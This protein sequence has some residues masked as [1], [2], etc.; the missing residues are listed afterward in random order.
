M[1]AG[2]NNID[3]EINTIFKILDDT[4]KGT[5]IKTS[6]DIL[7]LTLPL[8]VA[9]CIFMVSVF[10]QTATGFIFLLIFFVAILVRWGFGM[11][12]GGSKLSANYCDL[13]GLG[14]NSTFNLFSM[15]FILFYLLFPMIMY[16][17]INWI[18]IAVL[19]F[20]TVTDLLFRHSKG[21]YQ[22]NGWGDLIG[23]VFGGVLFG[24]CMPILLIAIGKPQWL[25]FNELSSNTDVCYLPKKTQFKCSVYKNG[26][27]VSSAT[28]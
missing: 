5:T 14:F 12:L 3:R 11:I 15:T 24:I 23:N 26:Q 2:H 7:M 13:G 9:F 4:I 21:C 28:Q 18:L 25:F 27:L 8:I 10:S 19:L 22:A 20:T 16:N 6:F 1:S 17:N